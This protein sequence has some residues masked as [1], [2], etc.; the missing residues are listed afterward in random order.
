MALRFSE[1]TNRSP[2]GCVTSS[3]LV[4]A[5]R[6]L[7]VDARRVRKVRSPLALRERGTIISPLAC[8]LAYNMNIL[9]LQK[10]KIQYCYIIYIFYNKKYVLFVAFVGRQM[11][12]CSTLD[13]H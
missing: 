4:G 2:C 7:A 9:I 8:L 10:L 1:W 13:A 6:A 12:T 3:D 5:R 11:A